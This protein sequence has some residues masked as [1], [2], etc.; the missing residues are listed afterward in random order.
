MRGPAIAALI[1]VLCCVALC[2]H[3]ETTLQLRAA[4][5]PLALPGGSL[6]TAD[7]HVLVIGSE[8]REDWKLQADTWL[9]H[10]PHYIATEQHTPKCKMCGSPEVT[11]H[12]GSLFEGALYFGDRFHHRPLDWY[13]AQQRPMQA[14]ARVLAQAQAR[15]S[16]PKWLVIIDDDT[17]LHPWNALKMMAAAQPST[18]ASG[19][20]KPILYGSEYRGGAGFIFNR[21][22]LQ[23]LSNPI[24]VVDMSW[25]RQLLQWTEQQG[26]SM[27]TG[28]DACVHRLMGGS[29]CYMHSDH[30][31]GRCVQSLG[32]QLTDKKEVM[33]QNCPVGTKIMVAMTDKHEE[34]QIRTVEAADAK[35][36]AWIRND[37]VS[38]HH[39]DKTSMDSTYEAIKGSWAAS[40]SSK[41]GSAGSGGAGKAAPADSDS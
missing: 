34:N 4:Q 31:M 21:A 10:F 5:V 30:A 37:M 25:D 7:I 27:V 15:A 19:L 12:K 29:W 33:E 23:N 26:G 20:D 3:A 24:P 2:V 17:A 1:V 11:P 41:A 36:Q 14:L 13:C 6:S 16:L 39:M 9:Q 8:T 38:C 22:A 18:A 32:M 28:M 35:T 40:S